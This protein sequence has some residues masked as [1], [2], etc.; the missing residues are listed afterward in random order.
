LDLAP[1]RFGCIRSPGGVYW[2]VR[3]REML[4]VEVSRL[5]VPDLYAQLAADLNA[6]TYVGDQ[7]LFVEATV[8][9]ALELPSTQD[10]V[11]LLESG[12]IGPFLTEWTSIY[13]EGYEECP[14]SWCFRYQKRG[15]ADEELC[16]AVCVLHRSFATTWPQRT[17][18]WREAVLEITFDGSGRP[19]ASVSVEEQGWFQPVKHNFYTLKRNIPPSGITQN[20]LQL[21]LGDT[22]EITVVDT[23]SPLSEWGV[24]ASCYGHDGQIQRVELIGR[25]K[26]TASST[27]NAP[28]MPDNYNCCKSDSYQDDE[29][30]GLATLFFAGN[31]IDDV[32]LS[33]SIRSENGTWSIQCPNATGSGSKTVTTN[34]A[35]IDC[36]LCGP[37]M[38]LLVGEIIAYTVYT[39]WTLSAGEDDF[40]CFCDGSDY[41]YT[42]AFTWQQA[43]IGGD[44]N[45]TEQITEKADGLTVLNHDTRWAF[46]ASNAAYTW[47]KDI[48]DDADPDPGAVVVV[49]YDS[50][51]QSYGGQVNIAGAIYPAGLNATGAE[52]DGKFCGGV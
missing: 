38:V 50:L 16:G 25:N 27:G 3:L 47:I 44:Y 20:Y 42:S 36:V 51:A 17:V 8:M 14:W 33:G 22:E 19:S 23:S 13:S 11:L 35:A 15:E 40:S 52:L 37:G 48:L 31:T 9:G 28:G 30:I 10:T 32:G 29:H 7:A 26:S 2:L 46:G 21:Y 6:G 5:V 49:N 12:Q 4:G 1:G 45:D 18:E 43:Q 41:D 34:N 39:T 24:V